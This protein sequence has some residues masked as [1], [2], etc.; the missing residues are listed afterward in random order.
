MVQN[1]QQL[2]IGTLNNGLLI[3]SDE[4]F[5]HIGT[6]HGLMSNTILKMKLFNDDLIIIEPGYMQIWNIRSKTFSTT[7]PLPNEN[8]GS[9][10]DF[11]LKDGIV[12]MHFYKSLYHL[13]LSETGSIPPVAYLLSAIIGNDKRQVEN[14]VIL[15]HDQN[16]IQFLLSSP[17]YIHADATY[18]MY[19]LAGSNDSSWKRLNPPA[20]T[21][22]YPSLR[23]GNYHLIAYAVNFKGERSKNTLDF[24]FQIKLPWWQEWWFLSILLILLALIMIAVFVLILKTPI[25]EMQS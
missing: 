13:D 25:N 20:Y 2:F 15:E 8:Q 9:V 5:E 3:Y 21:I 19:Q 23:P 11:L 14:N 10:H 12:Y 24:Q 6:E 17:S 7:A 4:K 1:E 16:S 22:N 18:F